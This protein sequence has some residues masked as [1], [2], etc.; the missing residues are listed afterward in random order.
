MVNKQTGLGSRKNRDCFARPRDGAAQQKVGQVFSSS[1]FQKALIAIHID[2]AHTIS[3]WGG[4]FQKDYKGLGRIRARLPKGV[5]VTIVSTTLQPG[6]KQDAMSTLS[7]SSNALDYEDINI[8]N[9]RPNVFVGAQA[10]K[11]PASSFRDL[12][13]FIDCSEI[14]PSNIPKNTIYID[15]FSE[16]TLAVVT[17]NN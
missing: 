4:N 13:R 14:N 16:V 10:M 15:N 12:S 6:L 3:S 5:P 1:A 2:E 7:F 11:Y 9:E 8:G 17:L